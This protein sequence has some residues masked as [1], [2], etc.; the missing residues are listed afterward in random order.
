MPRST[1]ENGKWKT[2][3]RASSQP[4]FC[5][6]SGPFKL[7]PGLFLLFLIFALTPGVEADDLTL[8]E[9][10]SVIT[11]RGYQMRI[12]KAREAAAERGQ[13]QASA[14]LRPQVT[15]YADQTWLQNRPEAVFGAGTSPLSED[16]FL[17]Y[18]I[19]VKQLITD[20]GQ[21]GSG[22]EAAKAAARSQ[23]EETGLTLNTVTLDYVTAYVSLLQAEKTMTLT[24]LEVERFKSHVSDA[25]ALHAAGEVTLHDVLAAEVALADATLRRITT[26]DERNLA[27][28][29]LNYL[30]MRP[31]DSPA[32]VVDFPF[33]L[34]TVPNLED[35][36]QRAMVNRPELKVL[37]ERIAAKE[38]EL[39]SRKAEGFPAFY[40]GGGYAYEENPYR[41]HEDNWSATV[42]LT[43]ELYTGG[44]RTAGQKLLMEEI[45][46]LIIQREQMRELV[47]LQ[48]IDSRRLL[49]GTVERS[50]VTRKAVA[51]AEENLRLQ[52]SRYSEGEATATEVTDAM[53]SLARAEDNHWTA[54]YGR[55]KAEASLLFATGDDLVAVYSGNGIT[56][57]GDTS[58][59]ETGEAR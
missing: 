50:T 16:K 35:A 19:T 12:A 37:T 11:S 44:A 59:T 8:Q 6:G 39:N 45:N 25:K 27:A 7:V 52:R 2:E 48:V 5:T 43:W 15:A 40:V 13:D 28:S 58:N 10:L 24:E 34:D 30:I 26:R 51:Q 18:G 38:A 36:S 49:T 46:A 56:T 21:T 55:L 32:R 17:R 31:L 9:G 20:F 47:N 3:K 14:R 54:V 53:T 22:I 42:G 41:V 57:I 4:L 23:L 29:R 1:M 33:R